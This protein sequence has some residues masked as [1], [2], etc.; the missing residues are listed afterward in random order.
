MNQGDVHHKAVN[1]IFGCC[2]LTDDLSV[3]FVPGV[4]AIWAQIGS[5]QSMDDDE[6]LYVGTS[7]CIGRRLLHGHIAHEWA[8]VNLGKGGL[9]YT[10]RVL[11]SKQ[12]RL[13]PSFR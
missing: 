10:F 13:F 9:Y 11:R 7:K 6:C 3:A 12:A 5:A 8:I 1:L 2:P 4:Y